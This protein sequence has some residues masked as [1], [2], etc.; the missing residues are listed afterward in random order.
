MVMSALCQKA[1]ILH[2]SKERCYSN[3]SSA[4][5]RPTQLPSGSKVDRCGVFLC[6]TCT[7]KAIRVLTFDSAAPNWSPSDMTGELT[8]LDVAVIN[9]LSARYS[10]G[11]EAAFDEAASRLVVAVCAVLAHTR[12]EARL[13]DLIKLVEAVSATGGKRAGSPLH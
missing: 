3:I 1:D 11:G 13:R 12:G 4:L 10:H 2:C 8:D 5:R 6:T 7:K 9:A